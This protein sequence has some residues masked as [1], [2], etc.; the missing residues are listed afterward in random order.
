MVS[1]KDSKL[2]LPTY[3]HPSPPKNH[4]PVLELPDIAQ[5][6]VNDKVELKWVLGP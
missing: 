2:A 5:A 3:L 4:P 6:M 1:H